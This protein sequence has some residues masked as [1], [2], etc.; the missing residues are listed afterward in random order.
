MAVNES[1]TPYCIACS[2][3]NH[4]NNY[5]NMMTASTKRKKY[6]QI[7]KSELVNEFME[8]GGIYEKHCRAMLYHTFLVVV[9]GSTVLATS[10]EEE[11]WSNEIHM[12]FCRDHLARY[13]PQQT[14]E[15]IFEG[16]GIDDDASIEGAALLYKAI[17]EDLYRKILYTH[18]S[19]VKKQDAS[20]IRCNFEHLLNDLDRRNEMPWEL[21][22]AMYHIVDGCAVQY[23]S[24]AVL[25]TMVIISYSMRGCYIRCVQAPGHGKEEVD[26]PIGNEKT[27]ADSIFAR[28][29]RQAKEDLQEHELE[30]P[31][32]RMVNGTKTSLAKMLYDIVQYLLI[33][34]GYLPVSK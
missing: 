30:A 2:A 9:L 5:S 33:Q 25:Y 10:V 24:S 31:M 8:K 18:L 22:Q 11:V 16:I 14:G 17:R 29:G 15:I 13:T 26:G 6:I 21:L 27:Y 28:P 20:T 19:D 32:H 7:M 12:L 4:V 3:D 23:Q 34:S 1:N